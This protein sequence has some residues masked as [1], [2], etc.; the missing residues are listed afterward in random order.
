MK[1]SQSFVL[2]TLIFGLDRL[3]AIV[4]SNHS[5]KELTLIVTEKDCSSGN[6]SCKSDLRIIPNDGIVDLPLPTLS[7]L[8]E[9][10]SK[11]NLKLEL[12]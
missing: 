2:T 8:I 12:Q 1:I 11:K 7:L 5:L 9:E 10:T 3:T 6:S 4:H